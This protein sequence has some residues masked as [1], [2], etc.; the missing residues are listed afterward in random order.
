MNL[1]NFLSFGDRDFLQSVLYRVAGIFLFI[2]SLILTLAPAVRFHS[3][4]VSYRWEH[5]V[6]FFI[7]IGSFYFTNKISQKKMSNRDPYLLPIV[8]LLM[9]IGLLTI[10]RLNVN[11]GLRQSLWIILSTIILFVSFQKSE[12][13][14]DFGIINISGYYS[15][16]L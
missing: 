9:G 13:L 1:I 15:G 10:F 6:G 12:W 7:C 8:S 14:R 3:W 11:F 4:N 5:W 16:W 2:Y